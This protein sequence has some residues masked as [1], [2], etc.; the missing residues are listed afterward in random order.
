MKSM[1]KEEGLVSFAHAEMRY[2]P[3]PIAYIQPF[4]EPSVYEGLVDSWPDEK[5]FKSTA[6]LG[7]KASLSEKYNSDNYFRFLSTS[8]QWA[9]FHEFIKSDFFIEETLRFLDSKNVMLN[10]DNL[11][12]VS[13]LGLKRPSL[14]GRLRMQQEIS[15]R[16]EFSLMQAHSGSILPHTDSPNKLITLVISMAHPG[17]WDNTWGG[18]TE[19]CLPKDKTKIFNEVN[20][21][22]D[23]DDVYVIDRFPFV[24]NQCILFVKTYNSW[25]QV[26]PLRGPKNA[27]MR[28]TLTVNIERIS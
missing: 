20:R 7:K 3:Y 26:A 11:R 1:A 22:M 14:M 6:E 10:L 16:F 23:F 8:P 19:I 15:A 9:R 17:E 27:P 25:H 4:V 24:P 18:G 28:K 21:Y 13:K 2:E 12:I 5:L